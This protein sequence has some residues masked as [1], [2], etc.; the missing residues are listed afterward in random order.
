MIVEFADLILWVGGFVIL[1]TNVKSI[2]K[3]KLTM[4]KSFTAIVKSGLR[5]FLWQQ[6]E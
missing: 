2:R 4:Q 6:I 1:W 3:L 5:S